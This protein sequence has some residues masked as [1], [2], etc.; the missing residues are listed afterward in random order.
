MEHKDVVS[1][2]NLVVRKHLGLENMT[3]M[4]SDSGM[5]HLGPAHKNAHIGLPFLSKLSIFPK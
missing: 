3:Q 5:D 4:S 2:R 1:V